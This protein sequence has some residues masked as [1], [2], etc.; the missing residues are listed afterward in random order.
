[1]NR[2]MAGVL[3]LLLV[4]TALPAMAAD[5]EPGEFRENGVT[6]RYEYLHDGTLRLVEGCVADE[7]VR[8]VNIPSTIEGHAVTR[9]GAYAF[10]GC[11]ASDITI[12]AHV[13]VIEAFAFNGCRAIRMITIPSTVYFI[14][15]NPF[16]DC[17]SLVSIRLER[18]LGQDHPTLEVTMDGVLYNKGNRMLLC[19]PCS[20]RDES[21]EVKAG[22]FAIGK[23]A[24]YGCDALKSI[25]LP[26]TV[27]EI[28]AGAF[29]GCAALT[30]IDLS[31]SILS[32]GELAFAG[33]A[34]LEEVTLP[35]HLT[36]V[37]TGSF[38]GCEALEDAILP[39]N[40]TEIGDRAFYGCRSL[41]VI[42]LP[43]HVHSIG[44]SAFGGCDALSTVNIPV[45]VTSIGDS[46]FSQEAIRLMVLVQRYSYA[47]I[48]AKIYHL[49][50]TYGTNDDFLKYSRDIAD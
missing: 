20:K 11:G 43:D 23:N 34:A 24:F 36:H 44:A 22:T 6:Y 49:N 48:Y 37:E 17:D 46:A 30:A 39:Q 31:D 4:L 8:T 26:D 1:M 16:T 45:T 27:T 41:R 3:A 12:P 42:Q 33:C 32:I 40:L 9:I 2:F 50:Y 38:F 13:S 15:G 7:G 14:D 10:D 21:F 19:Y 28:G 5:N 35:P 29:A 18:P 47:E 25:K